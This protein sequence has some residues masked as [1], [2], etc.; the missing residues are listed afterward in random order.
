M[1]K[2]KF[3]DKESISK[4]L[5]ISESDLPNDINRMIRRAS[6][7]IQE[8]TINNFDESNEEHLKA[9]EQATNAQLEY[10]IDVGDELG[11]M[12]AFDNV[13]VGSISL[14]QDEKIPVLSPR[15][16]RAL[17]IKGLLDNSVRMR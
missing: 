9:V 17:L 2:I 16:R 13:S 6:E 12:H 11:V 1:I 4:Y 7:L 10:W 3:T 15:A 14:S 5:G 8:F